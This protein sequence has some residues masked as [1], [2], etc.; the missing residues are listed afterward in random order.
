MKFYTN[1]FDPYRKLQQVLIL[2]VRVDLRVMAMKNYSTLQ[3]SWT[4][5]LLSNVVKCYTQDTIFG[6]GGGLPP[7]Q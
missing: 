7:L 2:C 1:L 4:E 3:I 5:A 6:V